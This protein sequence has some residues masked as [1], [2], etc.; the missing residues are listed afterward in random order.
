MEG[1]NLF[2]IVLF[3][4]FFALI[5]VLSVITVLRQ[6]YTGDKAHTYAGTITDKD[7]G[8]LI[9]VF[10]REGETKPHALSRVMRRHD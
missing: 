3:S 5:I 4:M 7:T 1:L 8:Q 9:S 6:P 10:T 2:N